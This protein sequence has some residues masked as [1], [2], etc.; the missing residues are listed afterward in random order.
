MSF[1]GRARKGGGRRRAPGWRTSIEAGRARL[2]GRPCAPGWRR[3]A[4]SFAGRPTRLRGGRTS[5][6]GPRHAPPRA[7]LDGSPPGASIKTP[8]N[9]KDSGG[10]AIYKNHHVRV[11]VTAGGQGTR[12]GG[13]VPKQFLPL[14]GIPLVERCLALFH[15]HPA[16]DDLV[17]TLPEAEV[18]RRAPALRSRFPKLVAVVAGGAERQESVA[19]AL[20]L[21]LAGD[22]LIAI[23]DA[24]RPLFDPADLDGLL[25]AAERDGGAAPAVALTDTLATVDDRERVLAYP[26]RASLRALQTPQ[27]FHF[28]LLLAA[29]ARA[30]AGGHTYSDDTQL[31]AAAGLAVTLV[32]GRATNLKI[33]TRADLAVAAA[34]LA[35]RETTR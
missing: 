30:R 27:L 35:S 26:E 18:K 14:A 25:A 8:C 28:A 24:A 3:A 2:A 6:R 33:T 31:A 20:E 4:V 23:H 29:H 17:L 1:A 9:D 15:D 34:L 5:P 13:A 10:L 19:A 11:V 12:L 21:P 16:V 7:A 22:G 32:A